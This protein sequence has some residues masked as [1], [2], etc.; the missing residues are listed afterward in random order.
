[1]LQGGTCLLPTTPSRSS[2][3]S[4]TSLQS[5]QQ[6]HNNTCCSQLRRRCLQQATHLYVH[7]VVWTLGPTLQLTLSCCLG[8]GVH[9]HSAR[10]S[11]QLQQSHH[12]QQQR[13]QVLSKCQPGWMITLACC[14]STWSSGCCAWTSGSMK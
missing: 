3:P 11:A 8:K 9:R 4:S 14:A 10:H 12:P 13:V 7:P 2:E 6:L 5:L 1:M